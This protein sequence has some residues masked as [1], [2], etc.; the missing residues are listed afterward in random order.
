MNEKELIE[1]ILAKSKRLN[2]SLP[3]GY[4]KPQY[5]AIVRGMFKIIQKQQ[6]I[7]DAKG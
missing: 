7:I 2:K 1:A 5:K 3:S 6:K 4:T